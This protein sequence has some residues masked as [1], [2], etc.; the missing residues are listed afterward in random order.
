MANPWYRSDKLL[1][2]PFCGGE[3]KLQHR[4]SDITKWQYTVICRQ[5][6]A[7][8]ECEASEYKAHDKWNNR[9]TD[10]VPVG[11]TRC[12]SC[13]GH[14]Q[15]TKGED[16]YPSTCET[17]NGVGYYDVRADSA[18]D[19]IRGLRDALEDAGKAFCTWEKQGEALEAA[20][21]WLSQHTETKED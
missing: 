2:C 11:C 17:C 7:E 14:K 21:T 12:T 16:D 6:G 10:I 13:S 3:A 8:G 4:P 15:T 19:V 5:C 9:A 20:D 1:P 18:A